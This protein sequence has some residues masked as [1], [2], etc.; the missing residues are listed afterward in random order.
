MNHD[1]N[2]RTILAEDR[3]DRFLISNIDVVMD[4]ARDCAAQVLP[5]PFRGCFDAEKFLTHVVVDANDGIAFLA[6]MT[7]GFSANQTG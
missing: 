6:I 1:F 2:V 4:I 5:A 3:F 7:N